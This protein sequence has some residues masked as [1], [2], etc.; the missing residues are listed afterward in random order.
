MKM[1]SMKAVFSQAVHDDLES[2]RVPQN[3]LQPSTSYGIPQTS[4]SEK[5]KR[6]REKKGNEQAIE[7]WESRSGLIAAALMLQVAHAAEWSL[8]EAS[9]PYKGETIRMV[10]ESLPP[11]EALSGAT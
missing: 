9:K 8:E 5:K 3:L 1:N 11:L 4:A 7:A 2:L 10:G 6:T